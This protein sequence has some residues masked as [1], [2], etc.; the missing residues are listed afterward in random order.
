MTAG[1]KVGVVTVGT[2]PGKVSAPV[3]LQQDLKDPTFSQ[4][5]TRVN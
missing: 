3:A 1:T 5:L 2:G 4:K